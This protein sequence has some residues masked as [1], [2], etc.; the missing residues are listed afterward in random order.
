MRCAL[1]H[2]TKSTAVGC[3]YRVIN[4]QLS[5]STHG[6]DQFQLRSSEGLMFESISQN[7]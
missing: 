1:P 4:P 3:M 5:Q 2:F 6:A 7:F